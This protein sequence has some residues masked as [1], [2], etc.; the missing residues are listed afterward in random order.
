MN[1]AAGTTDKLCGFCADALFP[2]DDGY[3]V[4]VHGEC[5]EQALEERSAVVKARTLP[6]PVTVVYSSLPERG[7][8]RLVPINVE[9]VSGKIYFCI[10]ESSFNWEHEGEQM[11]GTITSGSGGTIF[12]DLGI[13]DSYFMFSMQSLAEAAFIAAGIPR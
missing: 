9:N 12:V 7:E 3:P 13:P 11:K 10:V 2:S 4:G 8:V 6:P 5:L 1:G